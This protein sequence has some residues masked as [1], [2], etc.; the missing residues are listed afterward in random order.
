[1][2]GGEGRVR[3][4]AQGRVCGCCVRTGRSVCNRRRGR[5]PPGRERAKHVAEAR[6]SAG[7]SRQSVLLY[8][9]PP[10]RRSGKA[11]RQ[12]PR[13]ERAPAGCSA[14]LF[15]HRKTA[16]SSWKIACSD[17]T[18]CSVRARAAGSALSTIFQAAHRVHIFRALWVLPVMRDL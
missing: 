17:A 18:A 3:R 4:S 10:E 8:G 15:Q 1:M 2:D 5:S 12:T 7:E 13:G 6:P 14:A 11:A 9:L 16:A